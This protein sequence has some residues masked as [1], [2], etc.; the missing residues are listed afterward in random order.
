MPARAEKLGREE[1]RNPIKDSE[2][3]NV[4]CTELDVE[5]AELRAAYELYFQGVER[6]P[7]T[8]KHD[9]FKREYAKLKGT[10]VRQTAAKF[11]IDGIGQKLMT[12]ERLWERNLKEIENGTSKREIARAR[13]H[14]HGDDD[15]KKGADADFHIDEDLDLSDLDE[16]DGDLAA[17]VRAAEAAVA[18]KPVAPAP[19]ASPPSVA[20]AVKPSPQGASVVAPGKPGTGI[21]PAIMPVTPPGGVKPATGIQAAFNPM[22]PAPAGGKPMI[23][24]PL[25]GANPAFKPGAPAVAA[26]AAAP[27]GAT[28]SNPALK[29]AGATGTNAAFKP[30]APAPG[31]PSTGPDGGLSDTKIKAIYDAYVMAKKRCGEDTRAV[32]YDSVASSLKKQVPELM[33]SHNAK[34]VEFKVVIKDGKA[35]LRALPKEE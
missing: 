7:P 17:A 23:T 27:R 9:A 22:A 1:N 2:E 10:S 21:A 11:R 18:A 34:S 33:K 14:R 16:G 6:F 24:A 30:A 25:T 4:R 20:P 31:R 3:A 29:P 35:V 5:L 32:T 13:R 26:S 15:K 28:G 19:P 12:F 8:K